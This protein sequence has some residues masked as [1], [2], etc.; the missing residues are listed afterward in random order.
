MA[1][2]LALEA[3]LAVPTYEA[4]CTFQQATAKIREWV[5]EKWI[6]AWDVSDKARRV[7]QHM[8]RPYRYLPWWKLPMAEQ[9]IIA[10]SRTGHGPVGAYFARLCQ[11]YNDRCQ[12]C[13]ESEENFTISCENAPSY[14]SSEGGCQ[15]S[16]T[17][18]GTLRYY[19]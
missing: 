11:N 10:Q 1:D 7:W 12:H 14:D 18:M 9:S 6:K 8:R 13:G 5:N 4:P 17:C 16:Q 3:A 19:T 15:M 2:S